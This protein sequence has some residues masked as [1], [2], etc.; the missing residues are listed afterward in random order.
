MRIKKFKR[1]VALVMAFAIAFT[2]SFDIENVTRTNAATTLEEAQAELNEIQSQYDSGAFGFF[3]YRSKDTSLSDSVRAGA[4]T[5]LDI[6]NGTDSMSGTKPSGFD[7]YT[8][9]GDTKGATAL[10]N[11][12]HALKGIAECNDCRALENRDEG[13]SLEALKVNDICMAM[14]MKDANYSSN[15]ID[16][17]RVYSVAENVGWGY[18]YKYNSTND[19]KAN[20]V[21]VGWYTKEKAVY[22]SGGNGV[23]G[24]YTNVVH[25]PITAT[26]FAVTQKSTM[27]GDCQAQV[28]DWFNRTGESQNLSEYEAYFNT[29]Y[30][31]LSAKLDA[32]KAKV[33]AANG[34]PTTT[35]MTTTTEKATTT[36]V[37]T[38]TEKAT[39]T[40]VA[41]TT[42]ARVTT[43]TATTTERRIVDDY[44][45]DYDD[46]D[47][48]Y[49]Y[50]WDDEEDE[51][52]YCI[53]GLLYD[54]DEI[55]YWSE[56]TVILY[57]IDED[58]YIPDNLVIPD[59]VTI[60]GTEYK[61]G[62]I[63]AF[64]FKNCED[65]ESIKLG[66]YVEEIG[67]EAFSGCKY[68]KKVT[69][70][71]EVWLIGTD[72]FSGCKRLRNVVVKTKRLKSGY[73]ERNTFKGVYSKIKFKCPSGKR[74]K[75]RE[76]FRK[77]GAPKK[78]IYK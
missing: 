34:S 64:A 6:L 22:K 77:A 47:D 41:T 58:E 25:T 61:V 69:I 75:Y 42:A 15:I 72:A 33:A 51:P 56:P 37:A 27:Y 30:A 65:I 5:A 44:D 48:I 24:H 36:A 45:Q 1:I 38:T 54:I 66:K 2:F 14:A 7:G 59:T 68:L 17:A 60:N 12:G 3:E 4:K 20:G 13:T 46:D 11:I 70:G 18:G 74:S 73:V 43:E 55:S 49:E 21:F 76:I 23:V 31:D 29:Y 39:T 71:P 35:Q 63:S 78:A 50:E 32:A 52:S 62:E 26:G 40:E 28:Y 67:T 8:V 53:D 19:L 16:H 10:S 9:K 57:G